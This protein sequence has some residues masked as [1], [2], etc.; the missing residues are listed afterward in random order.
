MTNTDQIHQVTGSRRWSGCVPFGQ[1]RPG[2]DCHA[3]HVLLAPNV[4]VKLKETTTN[5]GVPN[6]T[7]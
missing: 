2:V 3:D 1:T 5:V 6:V 4:S 7:Q